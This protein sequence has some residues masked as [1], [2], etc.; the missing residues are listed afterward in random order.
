MGLSNLNIDR[1]LSRVFLFSELSPAELKLVSSVAHSRK[2]KKN[3]FLFSEGDEASSFFIVAYGKF[4]IF[5]NGPKGADITLHIHG[6]GELVAEAAIFSDKNYPASCVALEDSLVVFIPRREFL[7]LIS[8]NPKLSLKFMS[9]YSKR[10]RC[11][12]K[13]IEELSSM[14][15]KQCLVK[16]ILDN[17][18]LIKGNSVV[19]L[20]I[21]KKNLALLLGISP[22]T[23][24]RTFSSL[25]AEGLISVL[26]KE[27][28]LKD[29][30]KL[31]ELLA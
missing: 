13:Q 2:L 26:G 12:V 19:S 29:K 11:F 6:E 28:K 7:D 18:Q 8:Q 14:D 4:K 21:S 25:K 16:Y 31:A 3:E 5:I 20:G 1:F 27:I 22:E 15:V 9:T 10:M 30:K 23:L 17:A 24:S